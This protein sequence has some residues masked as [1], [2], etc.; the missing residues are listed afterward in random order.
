MIDDQKIKHVDEAE[1][2][3]YFKGIGTIESIQIPRDHIT[4]KP[5]GYILIDFAN[6][7]EAQDAV[8]LLDGFKIDGKKIS[9]SV[10]TEQ[11]QKQLATLENNR[12]AE[13]LD[14]NSKASYLNTGAARSLLMHK[15][16]EGRNI[17]PSSMGFRQ[18]TA[19]EATDSNQSS[20]CILISNMFDPNLV[21]LDKDPT[22]YVEIK[23]Q[24]TKVVQEWGKIDIVFVEQKS[25]GNVWLRFGGDL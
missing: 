21:D 1:V 18:N 3:Q 4:L 5:K 23:N 17:D 15:L 9:V 2:R 20:R 16:M 10:F 13:T 11:L 12:G 6:K 7:A 25:L 8:N 22:F 14:E 24:I 19:S